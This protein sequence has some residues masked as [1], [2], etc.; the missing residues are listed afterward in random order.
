MVTR[1]WE[2]AWETYKAAE[3]DYRRAVEALRRMPPGEEP[4]RAAVLEARMRTKAA[5]DEFGRLFDKDQFRHL[6]VL[7]AWSTAAFN[8]PK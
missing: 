8:L 4:D 2:P 3:Q 5:W 7:D 6:A 1:A